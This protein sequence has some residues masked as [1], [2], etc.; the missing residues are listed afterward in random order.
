MGEMPMPSA[1]NSN[2]AA[3]ESKPEISEMA[4]D[5]DSNDDE[6]L[7]SSMIWS[8]TES[9]INRAPS[10]I[11]G[12]TEVPLATDSDGNKILR[13]F[14]L[15]A[16]EDYFKHPGTVYLFGKVWIDSQNQHVS[17]CATIKNID[18]RLFLLPRKYRKVNGQTTDQLV[19]IAD[20]NREFTEA[21]STKYSINPFK[22]R[23]CTKLYSFEKNDVPV[24]S[25]YLEIRY[26]AN[27]TQLPSTLAGETFSHVFGTNTSALETFIISRR[28]KGPCWIEIKRPEFVNNS[29]SWCNLDINVH[30]LEDIEVSK[31]QSPPPPLVVMSLSLKTYTNSAK[32]NEILGVSMLINTNYALDKPPP[33]IPFQQHFCAISKPTNCVFPFDLKEKLRSKMNKVNVELISNERSL[34]SLL[35]AKIHKIDPD[36]IVGHDIT[37]FD[38]DVLIHRLL[39]GKVQNWSKIGRLKRAQNLKFGGGA[40][41]VSSFCAGRIL[42]DIQISAK[43]LIRCRS[44]DLTELVSHILKEKRQQLEQIDNVAAIFSS[45]VKLAELVSHGMNDASYGF[46]I[47]CE[48]NVLPLALQITNICGNTMA[49]SLLGGRSERNEYLL[50]HAFNDKNF[51]VPDKIYSKK[52]VVAEED[53]DG[54]PSKKGGKKKPAYTGGLVLEPKKGFYDHFILLLDF[55][56]LYPSIIQEYNICFTTVDL[57]Q[58]LNG[59]DDEE[60]NEAFLPERGI[61]PGILPNEIKKLVESRKQVRSLMKGSDV[62]PEMLMQYDIRQKALKLTANSM[63]GCLGFGSSRFYAKRLASLITGKGREILLRT[64]DLVQTMNVE[65]IYGDTDSIM[66]NTGLADIEEVLK[67][68]NK[69]KSEVNKHYRLLEIDIDGIFKSMLLLK[70][71]KYAALSMHR[72]PDGKFQTKQEMKGLDIVRRDWCPLAKEVGE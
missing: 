16:Y 20:V 27:Q 36:I 6:L 14:W 46:R 56:S 26:S 67:L 41:N 8:Q 64:K 72:M 4:F 61:E 29:V 25:D 38:L 57:T 53:E 9:T 24:E 45:S 33:K 43:E 15:D 34:L 51:I 10:Q 69:I 19:G 62:S 54:N 58:K 7:A 48:L 68:G 5:E 23:K 11:Y 3:S 37:S 39:V 21:V 18:R 40:R 50:L 63:Y 60:Y 31:D 22:S 1:S 70:K 47:M 42:C 30:K 55:N 17:C 2:A 66:I 52:S 71:K 32:E 65:V 35:V 44:Y 28:L 13:M 49:R 12:N 59:D